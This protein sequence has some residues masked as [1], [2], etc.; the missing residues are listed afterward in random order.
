MEEVYKM[1]RG[2]P[3]HP[4]VGE[5]A[6]ALGITKANA[7]GLLEMLWHVTA[8]YAPAGDIGKFSDAAIATQVDPEH[9]HETLIDTLCTT[10]WIDRIESCRLYVH[11][12]H[13]HC[14]DSVHMALARKTL[15]FANGARPSMS[16]MKIK[17]RK[18]L[19]RAYLELER[20]SHAQ[21]T[22]KNAQDTH[23]QAKPSQAKPCHTTPSKPEGDSGGGG[24]G[25]EE[26]EIPKALLKYVAEE[27]AKDPDV[28]NP[29]AV[30]RHR[31]KE[32]LG[33]PAKPDMKRVIMWCKDGA[34]RS[35]NQKPIDRSQK[36]G[37]NSL[38]FHIND[39]LAVPSD[40]LT[41]EAIEVKP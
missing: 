2:T 19:E 25:K 3:N 31:I 13:E 20:T 11:D 22:Q 6:K 34:V 1:K 21:D 17:E 14:E 15:Y 26:A 27:A 18:P 37:M 35:I 38:G 7:V 33:I 40:K 5:L 23:C 32:G 9:A 30:A 16:R 4:K 24:G 41:W 39:V 12:W 36:F 28:K 8:Q 10:Q 29:A